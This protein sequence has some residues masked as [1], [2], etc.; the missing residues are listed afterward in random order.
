MIIMIVMIVFNTITFAALK[1]AR[2]I[3]SDSDS[4]MSKKDFE[5]CVELIDAGYKISI[6]TLLICGGL[7]CRLMTM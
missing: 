5:F 6:L 1:A 4:V 7:L 2:K 3:N